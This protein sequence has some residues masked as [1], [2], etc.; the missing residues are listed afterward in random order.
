MFGGFPY[1]QDFILEGFNYFKENSYANFK[2]SLFDT[3]I[4]SA[5]ENS[6]PLSDRTLSGMPKYCIHFSNIELIT[7]SGFFFCFWNVS[8]PKELQWNPSSSLKGFKHFVAL[9]FQI[10]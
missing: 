3:S 8:V 10:L 4:I 7:W 9:K 6:P 2:F 5:L 1:T